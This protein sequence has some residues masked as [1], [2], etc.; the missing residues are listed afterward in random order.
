MT[1][2]TTQTDASDDWTVPSLT[3]IAQFYDRVAARARDKQHHPLQRAGKFE[4]HSA[5]RM[6]FNARKF[7]RGKVRRGESDE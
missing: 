1:D 6:A 2:D 4:Q 5:R 3:G 7:A